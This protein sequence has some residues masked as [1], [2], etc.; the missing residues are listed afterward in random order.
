MGLQLCSPSNLQEAGFFV[1]KS[2]QMHPSPQMCFSVF[3]S[4]SRVQ[5]LNL[6][7]NAPWFNRSV[8]KLF[9]W[10]Q[11]LGFLELQE[12]QSDF[13]SVTDDIV[14]EDVKGTNVI[15]HCTSDR[16]RTEEDGFL[17]AKLG[18][19][20]STPDTFPIFICPDLPSNIS[21]PEVRAV[22]FVTQFV[23]RKSAQDVHRILPFIARARFVNVWVRKRGI[24]KNP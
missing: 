12:E 7:C 24:P 18:V 1:V 6:L 21:S 20:D 11:C 9:L 22:L 17:L 23:G 5:L 4:L 16:V 19:F 14:R 8:K 2:T 3:N 15:I 13:R 10:L